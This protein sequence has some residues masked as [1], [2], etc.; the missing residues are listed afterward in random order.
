MSQ[1]KEYLTEEN[2]EKGKKKLKMVAIIV[3]VIGLLIGGSL[4]T[5]GI[6][7]QSKTNSNYSEE[8][9]KKLQNDIEVEKVNLETKKIELEGKRDETLGIE[10]RNLE[11]KKQ[12]LISKGVKYDNFTKY[13]DGE[14][15]DLKIITKA[16]DPSF[17][18]CAFDEYENN[19]L[20]KDYC[21]LS[22]NKDEDSIAI[23]VIERVLSTNL[24]YCIGDAMSNTYTFN[25]CTLLSQLNEKSDF[26][27]EFDSYDSI[28]FYMIGGFIIIASCMIA[29]SIYMT[30]KR[31][32][33]L[34]FH[35]QQVMPVA[36]EG[37]EKMAPT[38][39]KAGASIAKEMAPAY[40]EMA[41]EISKGI[42][43]GL[44]KDSKEDEK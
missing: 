32:E 27:K 39:G 25:Y 23:S 40:G 38:I 1:K 15:Y 13:D 9:I 6:L 41:K 35:A 20:T 42:K 10:K 3:L 21:L 5:V 28:P 30:T 31:R 34:A 19:E 2:Y 44:S 18:Y 37:I 17:N 26:N 24:S 7:K 16:L 4:I 36:Q 11:N 43:E 14:S 22:N 29:S 33:I 8:T 12:E